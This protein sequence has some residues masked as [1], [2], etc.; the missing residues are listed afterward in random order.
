M[1]NSDLLERKAASMV[2]ACREL[3][4][5]EEMLLDAESLGN[6]MQNQLSELLQ[7]KAAA[8]ESEDYVQANKLK[9]QIGAVTA[10]VEEFKRDD[11]VAKE[12]A[13]VKSSE[14]VQLGLTLAAH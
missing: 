5:Q 8:L 2:I 10:Q 11:A 14:A 6:N 9:A 1:D 3:Q 4:V 12:A 7:Q 13:Q